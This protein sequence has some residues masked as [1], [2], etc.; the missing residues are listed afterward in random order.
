MLEVRENGILKGG[1]KSKSI[2][3][4]ENGN[5]THVTVTLWFLEM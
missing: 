4:H 1:D 3:T 5:F 2:K